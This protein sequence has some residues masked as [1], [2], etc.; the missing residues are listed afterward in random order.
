MP[1]SLR[2]PGVGTVK[3]EIRDFCSGGLFLSYDGPDGGTHRQAFEPAPGHVIEI[4]CTVPTPGGETPLFFHG[5]VVRTGANSIGVSFVGSALA[6][7][8]AFH[9][10]ATRPGSGAASKAPPH[11]SKTIA[12]SNALGNVVRPAS[13]KGIASLPVRMSSPVLWG[14]RAKLCSPSSARANKQAGRLLGA[15]RRPSSIKWAI[16]C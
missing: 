4:R 6:A 2:I 1:A 11:G 7:L 14:W 15:W 3:A 12:R 16:G 9:E 10:F 13:L 5:R 8:N